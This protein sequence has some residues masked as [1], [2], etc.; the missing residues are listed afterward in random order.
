MDA[1]CNLD[2]PIAVAMSGGLD[3]SVAAAMLVAE[4]HEVVGMTA[5]MLRE[6]SRCCSADDIRDARLMADHLGI[7][8]YVIDM[9]EAFDRTIKAYFAAEY[10]AG[11][12]PSPCAVCNREIKFGALL[13]K[14]RA[15][16]AE[17]MV[18]GHY[19]RLGQDAD[20]APRLFRGRDDEKDQSYFLFDLSPEQ[21]GRSRFPLGDL[22]KGE[23]RRYA[24]E[25]GLPIRSKPESQDLC[26]LT[27]AGP[28]AWLEARRPAL[29]Q[30]GKMVDR[31][32]RVLGTH[33]GVHRFTIGQR[34]GLNVALGE[35]AY[36]V[37]LRPERNEVVIGF[38]E[39]VLGREVAV[40]RIN[41]IRPERSAAPFRCRVRIRYNHAAAPAEVV[42]DGAGVRVVFDEPQF[43][44]TPGQIAVFYDGDE[45]LGGGWICSRRGAD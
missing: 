9:H 33:E 5:H 19:A 40:E 17:T 25:H 18:T 32:G 37:A 6:G 10:A 2:G 28:A 27:D 15:T 38:R 29:R 12:T 20:G 16:G 4:G 8:L 24:E 39:D 1:A 7:P 30:P 41:W 31:D 13:D 36:V 26:F 14:V 23:V 22:E 34:K 21:L 45:V 43:A 44:I 35:R 11:R 42:P 3:S